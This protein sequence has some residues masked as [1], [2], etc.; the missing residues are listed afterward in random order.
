MYHCRKIQIIS[1]TI[2]GINKK[3]TLCPYTE[4]KGVIM[5]ERKMP[6]QL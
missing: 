2:R 5:S 3:Q 1:E 6:P 4:K